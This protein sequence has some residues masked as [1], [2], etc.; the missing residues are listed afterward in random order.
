MRERHKYR[1]IDSERVNS[2][3]A[4]PVVGVVPTSRM[5]VKRLRGFLRRD[6]LN[7]NFN[8]IRSVC[9]SFT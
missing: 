8:V 1:R 6:S 9:L 5:E 3:S 2:Q 4:G 7:F